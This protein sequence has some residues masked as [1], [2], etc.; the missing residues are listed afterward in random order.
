MYRSQTYPS[1]LPNVGVSPIK[2]LT[3]FFKILF[4][5]TKAEAFKVKYSPSNRRRYRSPKRKSAG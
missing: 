5:R 3:I 1:D 2:V 4:Y